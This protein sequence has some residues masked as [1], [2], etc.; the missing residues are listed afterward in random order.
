MS[1]NSPVE[2][3]TAMSPQGDPRDIMMK[4]VVPAVASVA[5]VIGGGD[6]LLELSNVGRTISWI[7]SPRRWFTTATTWTK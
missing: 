4:V 2:G 6:S 3:G 1:P 7:P 5:A